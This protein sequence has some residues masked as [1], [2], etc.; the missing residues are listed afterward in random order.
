MKIHLFIV[1]LLLC[2]SSFAQEKEQN[3][4]LKKII[5]ATYKQD[6]NSAR[7]IHKIDTII[8]LKSGNF[9]ILVGNEIENSSNAE[10]ATFDC[11]EVSNFDNNYEITKSIHGLGD[12]TGGMGILNLTYKLIYLNRS[13]YVIIANKNIANHGNY[14]VMYIILNSEIKL[15]EINTTSDYT[16][17]TTSSNL[18]D[19][20]TI[21]KK[22]NIL[23]DLVFK[24]QRILSTNSD[25]NKVKIKEKYY[26]IKN[27]DFNLDLRCI[28]GIKF[29]NEI[30]HTIE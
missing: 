22:N 25:E 2:T 1:T 11:F 6:N 24:V 8:K 13:E 15:A 29:L 5:L 23:N 30:V 3:K 9:F 20:V 14:N 17:A 21:K 7:F 4:E 18:N 16:G 27:T 26:Q 10:S 19:L 12:N 28:T